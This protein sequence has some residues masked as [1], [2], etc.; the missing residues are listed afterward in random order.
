MRVAPV[1]GRFLRH[2]AALLFL[3]LPFACLAAP[4]SSDIPL[5]CQRDCVTTYGEVLGKAL[6]DVSAFS[7]CSANCVVFSPNKEKGVYT[8]IKWQCVEFA[9]RWLL[10]N[11]GVVYGDVD[12]AADIWGKISV[13]T[14]VSDNKEI[15]LQARLNGSMERPEVG[16]LLIY[17]KE[18]LG[19]GH[20]AIITA[21]NASTIEV[22]EQNFANSKWLGGYAR[23]IEWL[24][25]QGRNWILDPYVI[26]WKHVAL[27]VKQ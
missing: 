19:T 22:A 11:K 27:E 16:D 2:I 8:G 13:V 17:A 21:V 4:A 1:N 18:F 24:Q 23:K 10:V 14:R 9:R 15:S 12:V 6:G 20:V 5:S 7:N 3:C 25:H 26:G